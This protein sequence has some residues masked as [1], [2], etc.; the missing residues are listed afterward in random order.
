MKKNMMKNGMKMRYKFMNC[1][2]FKFSKTFR[3][4]QKKNEI[5]S[6]LSDNF[7]T[8]QVIR[9][10]QDLVK[11]T[12]IHMESMKKPLLIQISNYITN[13]FRIFGLIEDSIGWSKSSNDVSFNDLI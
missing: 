7:D 5:H 10:L 8:P 6:A 13:L 3:F 2:H 12:N 4:M 11:K 9:I 1:N